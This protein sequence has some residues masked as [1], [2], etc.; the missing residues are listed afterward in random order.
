MRGSSLQNNFQTVLDAGKEPSTKHVR[1]YNVRPR[2]EVSAIIR[3]AERVIVEKQD[4][5]LRRPEKLNTNE[6]EL[7]DIT[8]ATNCKYGSLCYVLLRPN[9]T[10]WQHL[11]RRYQQTLARPSDGKGMFSLTCYVYQLFQRPR[12]LNTVPW[13][14][15]LLQK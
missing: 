15:L 5:V 8:P 13:G 4:V 11:I 1:R 14:E 6:D 12:Q 2:S 9:R 3:K 10:D 7:F